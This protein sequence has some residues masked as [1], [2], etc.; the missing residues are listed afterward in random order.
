MLL[1][2]FLLG[3]TPAHATPAFPITIDIEACYY[4]LGVACFDFTPV[5]QQNGQWSG[6]DAFGRQLSGTWWF[7]NQYRTINLDFFTYDVVYWGRLKQGQCFEGAMMDWG[8]N[9]VG[10]GIWDGCVR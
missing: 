6:T 5:L 10:W 4:S 9:P 2:A 3:S 1:A 7:N 8:S